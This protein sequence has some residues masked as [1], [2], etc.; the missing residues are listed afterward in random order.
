VPVRIALSTY[1]TKPRGGV[2]HTLALAEAFARAGHD[3]TVW[4]LA[5]GGD[6]AF[7]RPVDP[8]AEKAVTVRLVPVPE[9][10]GETVGER[11]CGRSRCWRRRST[12]P[13]TW[14]T[15]RTA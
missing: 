15:R 3:V 7:Y 5:R 11:S 10:E 8:S 14:C 13:T 12:V 4:A 6:T 2:V 1:S 9:I